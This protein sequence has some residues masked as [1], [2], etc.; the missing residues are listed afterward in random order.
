M[1]RKFEFK[2]SALKGAYVITPFYADDLRGG[3]I[4]DFNKS[5]FRENGIPYEMKETFY[6]V[7]KKGVIRAIHFQLEKQQPKLVRCIKGHVF[8]VIV[9]LRA[10]SPTFKQWEAYDLTEEN[11]LELLVP[12]GFGHG[13]LVL[14]D[15]IVSYK[16]AEEFYGPGD[17]GIMYNDPEIGITWPFDRIG[18]FENLIISDKDKNLMTIEAYLERLKQ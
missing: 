17:S 15:S 5:I 2:E 1:I 12:E 14:E 6:T 10:D 13:Y 7:S 18:G 4:K 3:F 16:C 8:D 9:D 11:Q